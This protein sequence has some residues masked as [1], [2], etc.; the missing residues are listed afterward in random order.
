MC[1][2]PESAWPMEE[3]TRSG[4]RGLARGEQSGE[5]GRHVC[6]IRRFEFHPKSHMEPMKGFKQGNDV[7]KVVGLALLG[8]MGFSPGFPRGRP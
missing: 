2:G 6:P 7:V 8:Q 5:W 3:P 4:R 1:E